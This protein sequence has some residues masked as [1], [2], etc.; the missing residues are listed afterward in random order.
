M[1]MI[2]GRRAA[3]VGNMPVSRPTLN[4]AHGIMCAHRLTEF[5]GCSRNRGCRTAFDSNVPELAV[6]QQR[7]VE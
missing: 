6:H 3:S 1:K 2:R 7:N 5:Q 4:T